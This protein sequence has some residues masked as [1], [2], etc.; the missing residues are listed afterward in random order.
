MP[1]VE[2]LNQY[3]AVVDRSF[4]FTAFWITFV[5]CFVASAVISLIIKFGADLDWSTTIFLILGFWLVTFLFIGVGVGD[6]YAHETYATEYEVIIDS[7]VS[8]LDFYEKY[9][10]VDQRGKVFIVRDRK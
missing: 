3:T 1:G 2:V 4:N 9:E 7:S 5:I 10:V 8:M 6:R